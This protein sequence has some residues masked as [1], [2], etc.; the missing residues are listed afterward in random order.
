MSAITQAQIKTLARLSRIHCTPEQEASLHQDLEKI[1]SYVAQLDALDTAGV[2]PCQQVIER[3]PH[4]EFMNVWVE[5][6]PTDPLPR[7][8]FLLNAPDNIAGMIRVPPVLN[9]E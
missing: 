5:D 7:D 6:L 4:E 1:L 8:L 3:L 9:Q 2:P